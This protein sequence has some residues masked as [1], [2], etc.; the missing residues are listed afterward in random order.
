[1]FIQEASDYPTF[2][3]VK[4][5]TGTGD[6]NTGSM[7]RENLKAHSKFMTLKVLRMYA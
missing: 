3:Q 5:S 6:P 4:V 7:A 1:V 2:S